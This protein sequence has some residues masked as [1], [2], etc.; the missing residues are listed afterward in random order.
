MG[1]FEEKC[2]DLCNKFENIENKN[3]VLQENVSK[4]KDEL[5]SKIESGLFGNKEFIQ[6]EFERYCFEIKRLESEF[7]TFNA[8]V[9]G[10]ISEIKKALSG[11]DAKFIKE[12]DFNAKEMALLNKIERLKERRRYY[13]RLLFAVCLVVIFVAVYLKL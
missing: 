5:V 1:K 6:K 13:K 9:L 2:N 4:L 12:K 8:G 3:S 10:E 11:L 7:K